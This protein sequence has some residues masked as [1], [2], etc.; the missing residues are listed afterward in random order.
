MN[1]IQEAIAKHRHDWKTHDGKPRGV[2]LQFKDETEM[3]D[4]LSLVAEKQREEGTPT[5]LKIDKERQ[6]QKQKYVSDTPSQGA[7][8]AGFM[9]AVN[10]I[11][12][13]VSLVTEQLKTDQ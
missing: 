11:K 2:S 10:W 1:E 7:Y 8:S 9:D 13:D 5:D 12:R 3:Y 6:L 4:L